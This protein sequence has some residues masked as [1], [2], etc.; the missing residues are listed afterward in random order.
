MFA[1]EKLK[2]EPIPT[3]DPLLSAKLNGGVAIKTVKRR[4]K[5]A[6]A[7][8]GNEGGYEDLPPKLEGIKLDGRW[9]VVYSKYDLGCALENHQST[10]CLGHTP[11]SAKRLAAAA[12]LYSLK[13]GV[14]NK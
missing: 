6:A 12:V 5:V 1:A 3:D 7:A 8:G 10:D 2:L 14:D 4:E 9:V 13:R 11:E